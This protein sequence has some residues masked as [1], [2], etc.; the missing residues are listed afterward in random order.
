MS[1][2]LIVAKKTNRRP[3]LAGH[4]CFWLPMRISPAVYPYIPRRCNFFGRGWSLQ[5]LRYSHHFTCM[6]I[7]CIMSTCVY[8]HSITG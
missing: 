4:E 3:L 2:R 1:I 8:C 5:I 6:V 7:I